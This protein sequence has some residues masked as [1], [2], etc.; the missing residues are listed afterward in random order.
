MKV[1]L[2]LLY[3]E[4]PGCS[5]IFQVIE[6]RF[7][8]V[9]IIFFWT[10]GFLNYWYW[11]STLLVWFLVNLSFRKILSTTLSKTFQIA[12]FYLPWMIVTGYEIAGNVSVAITFLTS[13]GSRKYLA[14]VLS[15]IYFTRKFAWSN[16]GCNS[17][18]FHFKSRNVSAIGH[19]HYFI[20]LRGE[21]YWFLTEGI[22]VNIM[23][24][25]DLKKIK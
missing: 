17:I 25:F 5:V 16:F 23:S 21:P 1:I 11:F 12:Q 22:R 7:I 3:G 24:N 20:Q 14:C 13:P 9:N 8:L 15:T 2:F 18:S 6:V 10:P 4:T 19:Y